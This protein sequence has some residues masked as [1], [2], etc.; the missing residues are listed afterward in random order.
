MTG[1]KIA[2]G[3]EIFG[4]LYLCFYS[5]YSLCSGDWLEAA[6]CGILAYTYFLDSEGELS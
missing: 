1:R 5:G 3:I 2:K 6:I 4:A